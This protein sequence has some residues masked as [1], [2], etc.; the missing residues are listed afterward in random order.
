[1]CDFLSI[2]VPKSAASAMSKWRRRYY[3]L[4]PHDNPTLKRQLPPDYSAW[5]LTK[6]G[7]SCDLCIRKT[8][9]ADGVLLS[10][11]ACN[12]IREFAAGFDRVFLCVHAY[13]G[14]I[15]KERL[16]NL[17]RELRKLDAF[18]AHAPLHRDSLIEL[19]R[20]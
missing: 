20:R 2:A 19:T 1:M 4:S 14:D 10:E 16:P 12:A 9:A 11:D 8:S 3:A 5:V 13:S 18:G 7:C 17:S 15:S 6:G